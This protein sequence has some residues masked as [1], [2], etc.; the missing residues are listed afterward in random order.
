MRSGTKVRRHVPHLLGIDQGVGREDV[1]LL[2]GLVAGAIQH[3]PGRREGLRRVLLDR[4]EERVQD[5][6]RRV[7][8]LGQP[9]RRGFLDLGRRSA[10]RVAD[11]PA[12][13]RPL[14]TGLA[15]R[16]VRRAPPPARA[17]EVGGVDRSTACFLH[18][19]II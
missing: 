3:V 14:R 19:V 18:V 17:G 5:A 9:S 15:V 8:E 16:L 13:N 12:P 6:D 1:E 11:R 10:V 4:C 2:G 7:H